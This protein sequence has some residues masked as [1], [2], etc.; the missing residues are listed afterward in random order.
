MSVVDID[1]N[2]DKLAEL[3]NVSNIVD[4]PDIATIG[5]LG[6]EYPVLLYI[7][8]IFYFESNDRY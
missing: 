1:Y 5:L 4:I 3:I 8:D 7:S 2:T 6:S